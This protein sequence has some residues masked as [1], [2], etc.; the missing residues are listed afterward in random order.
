MV[1]LYNNIHLMLMNALSNTFVTVFIYL[2]TL[3][4]TSTTI[5]CKFMLAQVH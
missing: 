4:N 1:T 5:H 2:L 3:I